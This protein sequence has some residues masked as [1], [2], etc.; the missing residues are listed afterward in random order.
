MQAGVAFPRQAVFSMAQEWEGCFLSSC[1][2]LALVRGAAAHL[3]SGLGMWSRCSALQGTGLTQI[4]P[5]RHVAIS[6]GLAIVESGVFNTMVLAR[7]A[8]LGD[9]RQDRR[10]RELRVHAEGD[11]KKKNLF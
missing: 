9:L 4:G 6:V 10:A 7:S 2:I 3:L 5:S 1:P 8:D 11:R